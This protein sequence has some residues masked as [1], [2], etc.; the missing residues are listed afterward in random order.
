[1]MSGRCEPS[2]SESRSEARVLNMSMFELQYI[3]SFLDMKTVVNLMHT[4]AQVRAMFP[5]PDLSE[6]QE[7]P[8]S[9]TLTRAEKAIR[10]I[11][12]EWTE[13]QLVINGCVLRTHIDQ[14]EHQR[15]LVVPNISMEQV[16]QLDPCI[17]AL[18]H[19]NAWCAMEITI[20]KQ[21]VTPL[22]P[23]GLDWFQN[24]AL[25]MTNSFLLPKVFNIILICPFDIQRSDVWLYRRK[26]VLE[27]PLEHILVNKRELHITK[28]TR[29][30]PLI[31]EPGMMVAAW[32][33]S[34]PIPHMLPDLF[35][36][37]GKMRIKMKH[38]GRLF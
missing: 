36:C 35:D 32:V 17:Q 14:V 10:A 16:Q 12:I 2:T 27:D 3:C 34:D 4:C 7:D 30:H 18:L 31:V 29:E 5:K 28:Y 19:L 9:K 24:I 6:S 25:H 11:F 26:D 23:R 21:Y 15:V 8:S 38:T 22:N 1:M 33:I 13:I 20:T 37:D